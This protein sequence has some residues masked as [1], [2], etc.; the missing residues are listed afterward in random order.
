MKKTLNILSIENTEAGF[1]LI[2]QHIKNSKM[3]AVLQW[4]GDGRELADA[5]D[6]GGWDLVLSNA[7]VTGQDFPKALK[8]IKNRLQNVPVILVSESIGEEAVVEMMKIG[9]DDFI[10]KSNLS[11]LV[12]AIEHCLK[13]R[14]RAQRRRE[15]EAKIA[16]SEQLMRSVLEGTTDAIFVK[17]SK[18][19]YLF[20]NNAAAN[21]TGWDPID[22]IG[23][24]DTFVFPTELAKG[25]MQ[26]DQSIM[27][28][29]RL[30]NLEEEVRD[31]KGEKRVYLVTKGPVLDQ[32][33]RV[34]GLFGISRD[35]SDRKQA[36]ARLKEEESKYKKLSQE[37]RALLDNVPDGIVHLSV[38]LEIRWAN[39][40]AQKLFNLK[41]ENS[42]KGKRC[43]EVF[44]KREERCS[45]CP[46]VRSITTYSH[47]I[48]HM[49]QTET[50]L[51]LEIRAVPMI[52]RDFEIEGIIEI[53]SNKT[54]HRKLETRLQQAEKMEVIG[55]L[56]EGI[57]RDFNKILGAIIGYTE[58]ANDECP[59][60]SMI[61]H[62]IGQVLKAGKKGKELVKQIRA[63]SGRT[64]ADKVPLHLA[65]IINESLKVLH[66]SLPTTIALVQD[67]DNDAGVVLADLNQIHQ[68]F[69]HL[70]ANAVNAME[71]NGG[72]LTVSLQRKAHSPETLTSVS[73][74]RSGGF[75]RLSVGDT[76]IG[77]A[78]EIRD[79]IFNPYFTTKEAGKGS[80]MGLAIVSSIVQ[81]HDGCISCDSHPGEGTVFHITLPVIA[82]KAA[83][84]VASGQERI[85]LIDDEE[86]HAEM[87]KSML[88]RLGYQVTVGTKSIDSLAAFKD[89][90]DAFDL[91][92]TDQNMPGMTGINLSRTMLQI[93]PDMPIIL[94]C[95]SA[96]SLFREKVTSIG[97]R[98]LVTKPF[99]RKELAVLIR[100]VLE[101]KTFVASTVDPAV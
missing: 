72:M 76:G 45:F 47:E 71:S 62:D 2:S 93:R 38:D 70:C 18:G 48:D 79:N 92:I 66:M 24:N 14:E 65:T 68:I 60:G 13:E 85:L 94:C 50:G 63:L 69:M 58:M 54:A 86:M 22:V 36:E 49:S 51:E 100:Q 82:G 88:E 42:Y 17:D 97:I 32:S 40:A 44:L 84:T 46:V 29:G 27:A 19:R 77:I 11:R 101:E 73:L 10:L 98:S 31:Y 26:S 37:Y 89:R 30:H 56:A 53:I 75:V 43:Y 78:P 20:L 95:E 23:H 1:L 55:T 74:S 28:S 35:I 67:I 8:L 7:S 15:S 21:L 6:R 96:S 99:D 25:I 16:R 52:N 87:A 59:E 57:A 61:A 12:P 9:L 34:R 33:G 4:V 81:N 80:G 90:P 39:M 64:T 41:D 91:V 83:D 3:D 5:L